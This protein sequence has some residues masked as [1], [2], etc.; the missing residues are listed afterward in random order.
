MP[1]GGRKGQPPFAEAAPVPLTQL[2]WDAVGGGAVVGNYYDDDEFGYVGTPGLDD[3]AKSWLFTLFGLAAITAGTVWV[4]NEAWRPY[5]WLT[6]VPRQEYLFFA[7][8]LVAFIG[9]YL[10]AVKPAP[11]AA[12]PLAAAPGCGHRISHRIS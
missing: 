4:F 6:P 8:C 2:K 11:P 12:E 10:I 3:E 1:K 5:S 9:V 7:G